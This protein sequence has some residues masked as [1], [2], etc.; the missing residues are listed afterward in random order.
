MLDTA[1][2]HCQEAAE[3]ALTGYLAFRDHPP[4]KTH[5]ITMVVRLAA[6]YDGRFSE[7]EQTTERLTP[8]AAVA[9]L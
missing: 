3:K 6:S 8:F 1:F 4:V 9:T 2:F 7:W 5:N